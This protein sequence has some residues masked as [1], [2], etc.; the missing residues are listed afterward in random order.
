MPRGFVAAA[1]AAAFIVGYGTSSGHHQTLRCPASSHLT[2]PTVLS[3]TPTKP[4]ARSSHQV[5]AIKK[6]A[7]YEGARKGTISSE[8]TEI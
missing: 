2:S 5:P 8:A 3:H 7:Q 1:V 4:A 6:A